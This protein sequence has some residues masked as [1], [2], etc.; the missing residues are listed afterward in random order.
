MLQNNSV[1]RASTTGRVGQL[2]C[3]SGSQL[4]NVGRWISPNGN[5]LSE[6]MN[7]SFITTIGGSSDPGY[8]AI[9]LQSGLSLTA[10]EEGVY[11]CVIPDQD[12]IQQYLHVGIY[13]SGFSGMYVVYHL[14]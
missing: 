14:G 13:L 10:A 8:I 1:V 9:E 2:Q 4:A 12:G 6:L 3:I 7:D 5:N 11:S